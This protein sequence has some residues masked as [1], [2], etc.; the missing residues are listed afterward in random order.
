[1]A[2]EFEALRGSRIAKPIEM[3]VKVGNAVVRIE[4]HHFFKIVHCRL[5]L[6]MRRKGQAAEFASGAS[7]S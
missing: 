3:P 5:H 6:A 2:I 1:M 7:G 4:M